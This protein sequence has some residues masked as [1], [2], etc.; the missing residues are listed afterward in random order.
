MSIT[1]NGEPAE[2]GCYVA[3]H[4]GQYGMDMLGDII[5]A[6]DIHGWEV[7]YDPR[8]WRLE[9]HE[10]Q[11]QEQ[12]ERAF[13]MIVES[14]N[15][16]EQSLNDVTVGGY[17]SWEDGEFFLTQTEAEGSIYMVAR[18]Y[19]EAWAILCESGSAAAYAE[20]EPARD[21]ADEEEHLNVYEFRVTIHY[22]PEE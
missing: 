4:H 8:K 1:V 10:A 6:Y 12:S 7:E 15:H 3:G 19:E 5:E 18:H 2:P 20:S 14:A 17:W 16:I 13:E 22:E 9:Y 11:T 21:Y